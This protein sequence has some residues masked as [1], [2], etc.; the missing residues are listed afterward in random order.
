MKQKIQLE[1]DAIL[2]ENKVLKKERAQFLRQAEKNKLE[3]EKATDAVNDLQRRVNK[4]SN[5]LELTT[6]LLT[7]EKKKNT[8]SNSNQS[9][10]ELKLNELKEENLKLKVEV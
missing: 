5:D 7:E 2:E 6:S 3:T 8:V 9:K 1:F 10:M 4:L